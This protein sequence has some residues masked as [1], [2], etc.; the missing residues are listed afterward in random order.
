MRNF[1]YRTFL[2][3]LLTLVAGLNGCAMLPG[4]G[5]SMTW[6][7]EVKLH[8]GRTILVERTQSF[9]GGGLREI[10]QG[11]PL[12]LEVLEFE[13]AQGKA[14]HW[15]SDYGRGYQDNLAPLVLDVVDSVAY[16]ITYPT[17]CHAYNKWKRP[18]PPYVF[19][20]YEGNTWQRIAIDEV[21]RVMERT[22]LS[23]AGSQSD[24]NRLVR[25]T[26]TKGYVSAK[27][28]QERQRDMTPESAYLRQ[29]VWQ[30]TKGGGTSCEELVY[31]HGAWIGPGDSI[32]KRM[33]DR[34]IKSG[35]LETETS[36]G[37]QGNE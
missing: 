18:N 9:D 11:A 16:L 10:G 27:Q 12:G 14:V 29:I 8:D 4:G 25:E 13:T 37:I 30:P 33:I 17:R 28:I 5:G 34:M 15:K 19:F 36:N 3:V 20:R 6:R 35:A 23:L 32:G 24:V 22:N 26:G 1:F 2:V 21:P 31:Y 7:E